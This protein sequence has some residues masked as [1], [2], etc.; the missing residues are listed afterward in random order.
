[1]GSEM[2]IR[3][4]ISTAR[5]DG[6][7]D[8]QETTRL[9]QHITVI[10]LD[11]D[12]FSEDAPIKCLCGNRADGEFINIIEQGHTTNKVIGDRQGVHVIGIAQ[13]DIEIA[14]SNSVVSTVFVVLIGRAGDGCCLLTNTKFVSRDD[15]ATV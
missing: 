12:G 6:I 9:D 8:R 4:S 10:G 15:A 14:I 13:Q 11:T 7:G 2:C 3:D 1:M 5:V